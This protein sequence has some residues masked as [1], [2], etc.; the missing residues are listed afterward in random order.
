MNLQDVLALDAVFPSL[1]ATCDK[2]ALLKVASYAADKSKSS[3]RE[4]YEAL[5]ERERLGS[6]ACGGGVAIPH[7]RLPG[8]KNMIC[9]F[10]RLKQ[11]ISYNS[12]DGKP[13]DMMFVIFAPVEGGGEHL[14]ALSHIARML[15]D[16]EFCESL[17]KASSRETIY[18]LLVDHA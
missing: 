2:Q 11:G 15:R 1:D 12:P 16:G 13:V 18:Q 3:A 17:R 4:I 14:R 7:A 9:E 5:I 8:L 6:T 10:V